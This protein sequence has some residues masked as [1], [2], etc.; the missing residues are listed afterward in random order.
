MSLSD[1]SIDPTPTTRQDAQPGFEDTEPVK[2]SMQEF[3]Q[4]YQKLLVIT[5]VLTG[6]IFISVWI[7]YSLNIALNYLIGACAGVVYL[8]MLAK[9]VERLGGEKKRLSKNRFA[10][11]IGLIVVATQWHDLQI[12][13]IFLGFLTYKATLIVYMLQTVFIPDS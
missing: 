10:L 6:I 7:V 5:L 4:L 3:Y 13:P 1:E 2:T 8:K 12:L 11:F 9:D